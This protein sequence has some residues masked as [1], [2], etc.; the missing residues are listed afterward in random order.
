MSFNNLYGKYRGQVMDIKDPS[1]RGRV[2]VKVPS[3]TN[4]QTLG[5]AESCFMPE[6]FI[7][8]KV[9]DWVW[10]E[11][12]EGDIQ[13]PVWVGIMPTRDYM[14]NSFMQGSGY[15]PQ[16]KIIFTKS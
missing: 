4:Q 6:T 3:I 13:R 10:I 7:L 14:K 1:C 15:N 9:Y 11:F 2:L 12:E 8:P 16:K 5:W